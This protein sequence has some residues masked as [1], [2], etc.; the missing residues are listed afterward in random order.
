MQEQLGTVPSGFLRNKIDQKQ[1]LSL[2]V[3]LKKKFPTPYLIDSY[4][5]PG[6]DGSA[7]IIGLVWFCSL[8][9]IPVDGSTILHQ[10]RLNKS[11]QLQAKAC[12]R[13]QED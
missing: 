4:F 13:L 8:L 7:K 3:H 2:S 5:W 10:R 11:L 9:L 6:F 1:Q 12:E